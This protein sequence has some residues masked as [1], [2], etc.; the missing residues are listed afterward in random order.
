ML[1][2]M[3]MIESEKEQSKYETIFGEYRELMYSVAKKILHNDRDAEDAVQKAFLKII[4]SLQE[5]LSCA[6]RK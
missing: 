4:K 2:Y 6:T 3:S 5:K 1:L